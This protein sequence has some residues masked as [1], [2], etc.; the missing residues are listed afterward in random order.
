MQQMQRQKCTSTSH[1]LLTPGGLHTTIRP[2]ENSASMALRASFGAYMYTRS[3]N[4]L[5]LLFYPVVNKK[6]KWCR[7]NIKVCCIS[8]SFF[9]I[10]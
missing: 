5:W 1:Q 6:D 8:L 7:T 4:A 10:C 3:V 9:V 2:C